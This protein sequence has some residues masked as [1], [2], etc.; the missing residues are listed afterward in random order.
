MLITKKE[1]LINN[2]STDLQAI[3]IAKYKKIIIRVSFANGGY[4]EEEFDC[5]TVI[6]SGGIKKIFYNGR[7]Q[8]GSYFGM[9]AVLLTATTVQMSDVEKGG[10]IG[11]VK[12]NV[13]ALS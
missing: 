5:Q 9:V 8:S 13:C 6:I 12:I 11:D 1:T 3:D 4:D 10:G 2:T 7:S